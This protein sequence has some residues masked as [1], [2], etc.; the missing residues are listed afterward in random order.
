M[1][2]AEVRRLAAARDYLHDLDD[3]AR[4]ERTKDYVRRAA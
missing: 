3:L 1:P 4:N 2:S